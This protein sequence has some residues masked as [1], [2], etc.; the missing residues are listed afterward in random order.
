[1]KRIAIIRY[2]GRKVNRTDASIARMMPNSLT[3]HQFVTASLVPRNTLTTSEQPRTSMGFWVD[4]TT[5]GGVDEG[6][7]VR[8]H[9]PTV[10]GSFLASLG[11]T[12]GCPFRD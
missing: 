12:I 8:Y 1:M 11:M 2:N 7:K 10:Q 4:D 9:P 5:G 6:R 3:P